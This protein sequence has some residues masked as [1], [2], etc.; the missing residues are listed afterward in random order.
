[1]GR[2]AGRKVVPK[3]VSRAI[4]NVLNMRES[5]EALTPTSIARRTGYNPKTVG[6]YVDCLEDLGFIKVTV[7]P[8]GNK[9]IKLCTIIRKAGA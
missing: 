1:M 6:K 9:T 4:L 5:D 3:E 8:V 2:K 7:L